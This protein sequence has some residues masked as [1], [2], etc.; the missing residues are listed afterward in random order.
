[1]PSQQVLSYVSQSRSKFH[2]NDLFYNYRKIPLTFNFEL[3]KLS[4]LFSLFLL[5]FNLSI[6][7]Q[8][9]IVARKLKPNHI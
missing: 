1:M 4:N 6:Y 2:Y 5:N 8:N 7:L 9:V 3:Q